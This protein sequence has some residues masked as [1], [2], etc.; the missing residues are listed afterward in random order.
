MARSIRDPKLETRTARLKLPIAKRPYWKTIAPGT[1]VGYRRNEGAGT[2]SVRVAKKP[3]GHWSEVFA[4]AD[5]FAE[6][7]GATV[8]NFWQASAKARAIGQSARY[9]GNAGKLGTVAE[10]LDSYEAGLRRRGTDLGNA[11]RVR[12]RLPAAFAAKTLAMLTVADFKPWHAAIAD[13]TRGAANR[14]NSGLRAALNQ[15]A[16]EDER[17]SNARVWEHALAALPGAAKARNVVITEEETRAVVAAAYEQN[18]EF[19]LMIEVSAV[20]GARIS[21]LARLE[22]RDLQDD[23]R[24]SRLLVPASA[25]GNT[26]AKRL[27]RRPVP[28][29]AGTRGQAPRRGRGAAGRGAAFAQG[30]RRSLAEI[31]SPGSFRPRRDPRRARS[32]RGNDLRVAAHVDYPAAARGRT[33]RRCCAAARHQCQA[34]R[35]QLRAPN[36]RPFRYDRPPRP[37]R[38]Q[39][40][41]RY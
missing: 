41:G 13:M 11:R 36:R 5:D 35:K 16:A 30:E 21:Q 33:H 4:E 19:G 1:S 6:A 38:S 8:M 32:G 22:V 31:Q 7:N 17:I 23:R 3:I 14:T 39:R 37:A 9:G 34:D 12:M 26:S 18:F 20:T 15:A 10:A 40:A 28:I 27:E 24:D 29:P 25:K 2:W